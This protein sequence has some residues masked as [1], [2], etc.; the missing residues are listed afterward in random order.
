MKLRLD[1]AKARHQADEADVARAVPFGLASRWRVN[2]DQFGCV[3]F[4]PWKPCGH[5]YIIVY[6][7]G[8][9]RRLLGRL[10]RS[11]VFVL[12]FGLLN[13]SLQATLNASLK[14][15]ATATRWAATWGRRKGQSREISQEGLPPRIQKLAY[16]DKGPW[17]SCRILMYVGYWNCVKY[18][19]L[20]A[21]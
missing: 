13:Q 17:V 2:A 5:E 21:L 18:Q 11:C 20:L 1:L 16:P 9:L 8:F 14:A 12:C 7:D 15:L 4:S 19:T 10:D 6:I 3:R